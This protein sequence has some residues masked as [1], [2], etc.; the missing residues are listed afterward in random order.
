MSQQRRI[1]ATSGLGVEERNGRAVLTVLDA[2]VE[3]TLTDNEPALRAWKAARHIRRRTGAANGAPATSTPADA[4]PAATT[5]PIG[6]SG[7]VA[8]V[9]TRPPASEST[10]AAAAA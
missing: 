8:S 9:V 1:G 3:Q 5:T 10:P 7:S 4:A 2:I 6:E